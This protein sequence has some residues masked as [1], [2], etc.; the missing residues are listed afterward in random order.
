MRLAG[1]KVKRRTKSLGAV[2]GLILGAVAFVLGGFE[3]SV[4]IFSAISD[5]KYGSSPYR[6]ELA[7]DHPL[8][9]RE[10]YRI[11]YRT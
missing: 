4:R 6:I 2:L 10:K 3:I 7:H 11:S 5:G 9:D 1:K 8:L